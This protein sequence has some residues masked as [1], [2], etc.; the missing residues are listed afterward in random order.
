[1][2]F[3]FPMSIFLLISDKTDGNLRPVHPW[4][5]ALRVGASVVSSASVVYAFSKLPLS[6]V[7][8]ILFATPLMITILSIPI[9]GEVVKMRR[10]LAVI[11]GLGGA[12][13]STGAKIA[14][15]Q[16]VTLVFSVPTLETPIEAY[17]SS[18]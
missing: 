6:Q 12:L 5:T 15:G 18:D 8:A 9:L 14:M 13:V 2:L 1:M 4:W 17:P 11:V 3:G 10:W 16:R 7:Y